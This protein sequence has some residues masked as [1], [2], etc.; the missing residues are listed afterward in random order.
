MEGIILPEAYTINTGFVEVMPNILKPVFGVRGAQVIRFSVEMRYNEA[1]S[2][3]STYE[4]R[5]PVYIIEIVNDKYCT[6]AREVT[7]EDKQTVS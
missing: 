2:K 6:A 1:K 7:W 5:D 3:L 4:V